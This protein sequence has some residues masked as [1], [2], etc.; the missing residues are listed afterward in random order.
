MTCLL[1]PISAK[2]SNWSESVSDEKANYN[3]LDLSRPFLNLFRDYFRKMNDVRKFFSVFI[4][5]SIFSRIM[6]LYMH[7]DS[8]RFDLL[9]V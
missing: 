2:S 3:Y 9:A 7:T 1:C 8:V 4:E 6:G 5:H